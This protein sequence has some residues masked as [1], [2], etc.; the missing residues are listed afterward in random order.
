LNGSDKR[1]VE[2]DEV[3]KITAWMYRFRPKHK[4]L[5]RRIIGMILSQGSP[6]GIC[7][8]QSGTGSIVSAALRFSFVGITPLPL[9]ICS[10]YMSSVGWTLGLL[11]VQFRQ[12]DP[13]AT[14]EI[15][16]HRETVV[17]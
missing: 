14:T 7:G 15:I 13:I 2:L 11:V 6:Y 9:R 16:E 8:R 17:V 5:S 12:F 10:M 4:Y 3:S 1:K